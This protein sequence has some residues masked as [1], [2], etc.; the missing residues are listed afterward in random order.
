MLICLSAVIIVLSCSKSVR[1]I[2]DPSRY[3]IQE[4]NP[5][6]ELQQLQELLEGLIVESEKK[7]P[8]WKKL[9][10]NPVLQSEEEWN[11]TGVSEPSVL[12]DGMIF[13]M[14]FTSVSKYQ[15]KNIRY[16]TSIDGI[17]WLIDKNISL[18]GDVSE[19]DNE[20]MA[21]HVVKEDN[22]YVMLYT[23]NDI[24]TQEKAIGIAY[25]EDGITWNKE[26]QNPVVSRKSFV[27]KSKKIIGIAHPTIIKDDDYYKMWFT[28]IY[29]SNKLGRKRRIG[30]AISK[31]FTD[32]TI[33]KSSILKRGS[34]GKF[35]RHNLWGP[36][37]IKIN[38]IY[39][40]WYTG[41]KF[42]SDAQQTDRIPDNFLSCI[43]EA[44]S[45]DG[46]YWLKAVNNPKIWG[47]MTKWDKIINKPCVLIL[48]NEFY[49]YYTGYNKL[50]ISRIGMAKLFGKHH[51]Y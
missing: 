6:L 5:E 14:W 10:D 44:Y 39:I 16:A 17:N 38:D 50:N 51:Y 42:N 23:G 13:K 37:V 4:A 9:N 34:K 7:L 1:T 20:V 24:A 43:G 36:Y 19:W 8:V 3:S 32:W 48:Q 31:D 41:E 35:D 30:F 46:V 26:K 40:M 49:L 45:Y 11:F 12:Q 29:E 18:S 33:I 21:P 27:G 15:T 25:S 28:T 22:R 47:N 2:K